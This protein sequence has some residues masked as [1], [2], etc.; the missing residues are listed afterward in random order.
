MHGIIAANRKSLLQRYMIKRLLTVYRNIFG[1][2]SYG[3]DAIA[4]STILRHMN[5]CRIF[6]DIQSITYKYRSLTIGNKILSLL[7][8]EIIYINLKCFAYVSSKGFRE[9]RSFPYNLHQTTSNDL[10]DDC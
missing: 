2:C 4:S 9:I 6:Y 5:S 10:L 3:G 7:L 8:K 1:T